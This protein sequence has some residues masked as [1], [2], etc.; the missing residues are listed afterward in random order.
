[1]SCDEVEFAVLLADSISRKSKLEHLNLRLPGDPDNLYLDAVELVLRK[2][3]CDTSSF[4]SLCHSNHRFRGVSFDESD[5]TLK[6]ALTINCH[7]TFGVSI[8]CVVR[9]KLREFYF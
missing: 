3:V 5:L 9:T 2:L 4:Q 6:R 1:M 7:A 8:R